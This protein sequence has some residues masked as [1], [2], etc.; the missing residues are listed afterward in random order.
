MTERAGTSGG[1]TSTAPFKLY[2]G[3]AG[4]SLISE[5]GRLADILLFRIVKDKL[6]AKNCRRITVLCDWMIKWKK[7]NLTPKC[8]VLCLKKWQQQQHN[9]NLTCVMMGSE[10]VITTEEKHLEI[11]K[12]IFLQLLAGCLLT[13]RKKK[14]GGGGE[15]TEE[16]N[17]KHHYAIMW[18]H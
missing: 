8:D 6:T 15:T 3:D 5:V 7:W 17:R 11:R 16:Q 4:K 9:L 13:N 12:V 1:V 14:G 18:I 10:L 2:I